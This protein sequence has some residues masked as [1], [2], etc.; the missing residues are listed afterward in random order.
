M[1]PRT[2]EMEDPEL[3]TVRWCDRCNEWWPKDDEFWYFG[4]SGQRA[5]QI[6]NPC[7]AC[8]SELNLARR[9]GKKRLA[10]AAA[11]VAA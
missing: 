9:P 4:K 5:G 11:A 10:A 2:P 6:L 3:G 8:W 7:I 1:R